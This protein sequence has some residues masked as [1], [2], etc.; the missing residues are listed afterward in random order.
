[1]LSGTIENLVKMV[2]AANE[3][4]FSIPCGEGQTILCFQGDGAKDR[5]QKAFQEAQSSGTLS[6]VE[7]VGAAYCFIKV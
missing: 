3:S 5:A 6:G 1:M 2:L 7:T 4:D